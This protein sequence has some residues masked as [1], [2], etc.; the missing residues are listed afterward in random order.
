MIMVGCVVVREEMDKKLI[1]PFEKRVK[2]LGSVTKCEYNFSRYF[3]IEMDSQYGYENDIFRIKNFPEFKDI[4]F[5]T[6][7]E[8]KNA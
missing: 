8:N 1:K 4:W 3:T 2:S 5:I 7:K 6:P